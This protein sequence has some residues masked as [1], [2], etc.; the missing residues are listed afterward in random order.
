MTGIMSLSDVGYRAIVRDHRRSR[1]Q[2]ASDFT[3]IDRL[4]SDAA[5]HV[6]PAA[7]LHIRLRSETVMSQVYGYLDPQTCRRP[8]QRDSLFDI[9]SLTKLF[10]VTA[11]MRLVEAGQVA[12]D[13]AV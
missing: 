8:T 2:V 11:F 13:Q 10:V 4:M 3:T 12:L 6:F 1:Q 5:G 9:A 7:Q